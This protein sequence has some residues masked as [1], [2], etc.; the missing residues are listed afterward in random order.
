MPDVV[1]IALRVTGAVCALDPAAALLELTEP[2]GRKL[3]GYMDHVRHERL[4]ETGADVVSVSRVGDQ[5][6]W[7][8]DVEPRL[9]EHELL[10]HDWAVLEDDRVASIRGAIDQDPELEARVAAPVLVCHADTLSWQCHPKQGGEPFCT[11]SLGRGALVA[12]L[13]RLGRGPLK[14]TTGP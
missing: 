2:S 10:R 11:P 3:L 13:T 6:T 8:V 7:L 1:T 12:L 4:A 14:G 9:D 5:L